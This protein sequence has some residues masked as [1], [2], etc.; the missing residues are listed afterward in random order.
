MN[1]DYIH[2]MPEL[3]IILPIGF[4]LAY[5]TDFTINPQTEMMLRIVT[6]IVGAICSGVVWIWVKPFF[7]NQHKRFTNWRKKL[8]RK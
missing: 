5:S 8:K 1:N 2:I 3:K 4:V 7:E 6:S